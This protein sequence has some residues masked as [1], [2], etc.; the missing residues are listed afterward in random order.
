MSIRK[1]F[2]IAGLQISTLLFAQ[3]NSPSNES[4]TH[5]EADEAIRLARQTLCIP[6]SARSYTDD[7]ARQLLVPQP[8]FEDRLRSQERIPLVAAPEEQV[9]RDLAELAAAFTAP[10]I[11]HG[12]W[13]DYANLGP[14]A[15]Q[16]SGPLPLQNPHHAYLIQ[17]LSF[18][19]DWHFRSPLGFEMRERNNRPLFLPMH[20]AMLNQMTLPDDLGRSIGIRIPSPSDSYSRRS[21]DGF[22]NWN[23]APRPLSHSISRDGALSESGDPDGQTDPCSPE[24]G[25]SSACK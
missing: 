19:R 21:E 13:L 22:M 7:L 16:V 24:S 20:Q 9:R 6:Q 11:Q 10:L 23:H 5:Q 12:N 14:R 18:Y 15:S 8:P 25:K 1:F 2:V 3:P 17:S 4:Q